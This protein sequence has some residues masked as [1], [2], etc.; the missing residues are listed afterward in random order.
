MRNVSD[1]T[2]VDWLA[3]A[4]AARALLRREALS[5]RQHLLKRATSFFSIESKHKQSVTGEL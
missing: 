1:Y 5:R 3:D 4:D 2:G